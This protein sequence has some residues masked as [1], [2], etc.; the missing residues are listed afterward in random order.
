MYSS[1]FQKKML[2]I[3][4][5]EKPLTEIH[6]GD[7]KIKV[8]EIPRKNENGEYE[9]ID[10]GILARVEGAYGTYEIPED[11][12]ELFD[13]IQM[14]Y[15]GN[16]ESYINQS[17]N[18]IAKTEEDGLIFLYTDCNNLLMASPWDIGSV[19]ANAKFNALNA[20]EYVVSLPICFAAPD[21]LADTTRHLHNE[22]V[23]ER[24]SFDK[25]EQKIKRRKPDLIGIQKEKMDLDVASKL[26]SGGYSEHLA[27]AADLD[28]PILI[29]NREALAIQEVNRIKQDL[30]KLKKYDSGEVHTEES[31][32]SI[33]EN[34]IT[35]FENNAVGVQFHKSKQGRF[36]NVARKKLLSSI[37]GI[38][39]KGDIL[40]VEKRYSS[41]HKILKGEIVKQ[42]TD[43]QDYD[44]S[45]R[46]EDIDEYEFDKSK[47]K[48]ARDETEHFKQLKAMEKAIPGII[49]REKRQNYL[50]RTKEST[51]KLKQI[52]RNRKE[53]ELLSLQQEDKELDSVIE[54]AKHVMR[55]NN[56]KNND[57]QSNN[58]F[59][60]DNEQ[61]L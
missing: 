31:F 23:S 42:Y 5:D 61:N 7:K 30:S 48:V 16:C 26:M 57:E 29:I 36:D 3:E 32:E 22:L 8:Y 4:D 34:I 46:Y 19:E 20:N 53:R 37:I 15:H 18:S 49:K 10:F 40:E 52:A 28:I 58:D 35:R 6:Y 12:S 51:L 1:E 24:Y 45:S 25:Q 43:I 33:M 13:D 9:E 41:L 59:H 47:I 55:N 38:I 27:A 54:M 11:Y 21:R 56:E 14:N 39:E 60:K 50:I 2:K 17:M 44:G